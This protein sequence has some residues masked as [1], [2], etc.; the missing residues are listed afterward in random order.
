MNSAITENIDQMENP[1][2]SQD[3]TPQQDCAGDR[4]TVAVPGLLARDPTGDRAVTPQ[5]IN[6]VEDDGFPLSSIGGT[7]DPVRPAACLCT[8]PIT[9]FSPH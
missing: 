9:L 5:A 2:C 3:H 4:G 7:G 1:T 8:L 6:R